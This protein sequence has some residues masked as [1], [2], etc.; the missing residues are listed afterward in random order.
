MLNSFKFLIAIVL[1]L[2][3]PCIHAQAAK[4]NP[5]YAALVVN[6]NTGEILFQRNANAFRHPASLTKLMTLY[7]VFEK[8]ENG[9]LRMNQ[10]LKV[11]KKAARQRK[12][13]LYLRAGSYI[14]V[15]DAIYALI[16]KSANDA[17]VVL[18]E[19]I[20]K[21]ELNFAKMMTKKAKLLG[22]KSTS[23]RNANG[24]HHPRQITT[25]YDMARLAIAL[26]RDFRK[27]YSM[28]ARK[29]FRYKGRI[30][31]G[32]N[33]VLRRYKG[34]DGLKTGFINAAGYNL[35]TSTSRAN[36]RLV[37]VVL[38][39]RSAKTRDNHMIR[40]LNEGYRKL[41]QQ[42]RIKKRLAS[43][44]KAITKQKTRN[45]FKILNKTKRK[46]KSKKKPTTKTIKKKTKTAKKVTKPIIKTT[47]TK[48]KDNKKLTRKVRQ[49]T[50]PKTKKTGGAFRVLNK[51]S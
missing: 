4:G 38:G 20:G 41:R 34:A 43:K 26:R 30:I 7:L 24:L 49:K 17:A 36:G 45:A 35:V 31:A 47:K 21:T 19:H 1:L 10:K 29:S 5:K 39:G 46:A 25:A 51:K 23:F 3:F 6:A 13:K 16:I 12:S 37:G 27:Y 22:M 42:Q 9:K 28:F 15:R 50:T 40:I 32:H 14:T 44:K 8:L 33:H 11:S 48:R 2:I 18:A